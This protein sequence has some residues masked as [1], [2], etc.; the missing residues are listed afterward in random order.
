MCFLQIFTV[1]FSF[2]TTDLIIRTVVIFVVDLQII[3]R[4]HIYM[5]SNDCSVIPVNYLNVSFT[6]CC[7]CHNMSLVLVIGILCWPWPLCSP[8]G[9]V[10]C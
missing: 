5:I 4:I 3:K 8:V 10:L 7:E 9:H 2:Y 1:S 6:R